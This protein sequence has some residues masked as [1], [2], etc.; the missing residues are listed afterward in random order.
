MIEYDL[1]VISIDISLFFSSNLKNILSKF[2]YKFYLNAILFFFETSYLHFSKYP[3]S[4][5]CLLLN[6]V[7]F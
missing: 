1:R 6:E 7:P 3:V 4:V 5:P 2:E